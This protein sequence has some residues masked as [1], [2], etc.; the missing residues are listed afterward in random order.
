MKL[1]RII[2]GGQTGV[3]RAALDVARLLKI[4][5]GGWCPAGRRAEDGRIPEE[6]NLRETREED[7]SVR[8]QR[9][10][11]DSDGTLILFSPPL[12]G[13]T[14]FTLKCARQLHKSCRI[15]N[16][17]T[18][19]HPAEIWK[20]IAK[21]EIKVLNVAGP[22]ESQRPGIYDRARTYLEALLKPRSPR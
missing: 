3:D 9:N 16:L 5:H 21:N 19:D 12:S 7:Y 22:R 11:A 15:V 4:D 14:A 20:W 2:S 6:Y 13:G 18:P 1:Q 17:D 8:T 10:V